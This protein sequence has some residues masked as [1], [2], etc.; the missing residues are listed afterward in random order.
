[1]AYEDNILERF[2]ESRIPDELRPVP[3]SLQ[4]KPVKYEFCGKCDNGYIM[5]DGK[6]VE[7]LCMLK[8]RAKEYLTP[9]YLNAKY[10]RDLE[11]APLVD[12]NILLDTVSQDY[13]K[14]LAK[15]FLLNTGMKYR[16][17]TVTGYDCLQAYLTNSESGIF[18][19]YS[20]IDLLFLYLAFDPKCNSYGLIFTSLLEKRNLNRKPTWIFSNTSINSNAFLERYGDK[21][22]EYCKKNFIQVSTKK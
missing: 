22:S 7:C 2:D 14:S 15:S 17:L 1:M 3:I 12:N 20:T 4:P 5:Q 8:A 11:V 18:E 16:H 6:R 13:F 9:T 10:M 19:H 21:L